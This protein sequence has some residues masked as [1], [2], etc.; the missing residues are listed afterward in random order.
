MRVKIFYSATPLIPIFSNT[1]QRWA[2]AVQELDA[3]IAR[4]PP[5]VA[6]LDVHSVSRLCS[7][8]VCLP[9]CGEFGSQLLQ[10]ILRHGS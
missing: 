2:I 5:K 7:A 6:R 1:T 10:H 3:G 9:L 8:M 4:H